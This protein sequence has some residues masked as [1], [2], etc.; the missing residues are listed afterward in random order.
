MFEILTRARATSQTN[1]QTNRKTKSGAR[2]TV[3]TNHVHVPTNGCGCGLVEAHTAAPQTL[4]FLEH[5]ALDENPTES[6]RG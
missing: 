4:G 6:D 2:R 1:K 3:S 5:S